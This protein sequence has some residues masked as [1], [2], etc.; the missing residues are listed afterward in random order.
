LTEFNN[1]KIYS[2]DHATLEYYPKWLNLEI[3]DK[4][5]SNLRHQLNWR[6]DEITLFGKTHFVPRLQAFYSDLGITYSYSNI[7]LA[8]LAWNDTLLE[9]KN[10]IEKISLLKF[11][12]VLCNLYRNGR[13]YAA[14]H[15]DDEKEL[16]SDPQIASVSLGAQRIFQARHKK[17][18]QFPPLKLALEH[19]SLLLMRGQ[20]QR[21]WSHQLAKT[22]RPVGE[23]INLTFRYIY[24]N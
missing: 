22:A 8:G 17:L 6:Q 1:L 20:M 24:P 10:E 12:C 15:S 23:R 11:N 18:K 21:Y 7:K 13:D 2:L 3:A 16:G 5:F 19:G 9:I 14:W 4:H